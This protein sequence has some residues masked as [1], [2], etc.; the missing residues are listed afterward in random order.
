MVSLEFC[1]AKNIDLAQLV[2]KLADGELDAKRE[3]LSDML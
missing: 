3:D 1:E 2:E